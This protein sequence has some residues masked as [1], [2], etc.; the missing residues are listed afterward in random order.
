MLSN[1]LGV[2]NLC[3]ASVIVIGT[4]IFG[5]NVLE[6]LDSIQ[7]DISGIEDNV[8]L[9]LKKDFKTMKPE[10]Y[11]EL[12]VKSDRIFS[13]VSFLAEKHYDGD[14][15]HPDL[16]QY[17][18]NAY[19]SVMENMY[20][21]MFY[22]KVYESGVKIDMV[23]PFQITDTGEYLYGNDAI[24]EDGILIRQKYHLNIH[25]NSIYSRLKDIPAGLMLMNNDLLG[26]PECSAEQRP[27]VMFGELY[28]KDGQPYGVDLVT[29]SQ[30]WRVSFK[31]IDSLS[32]EG[33]RNRLIF[34]VGCQNIQK[35]IDAA[36]AEMP[37]ESD[38]SE[39]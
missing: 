39:E 18:N 22:K 2:A 23:K 15:F 6:T 25:G 12:L 3:L 37:K 10:T 27:F 31:D 16:I 19:D 13:H 26:Y 33:L 11:Q 34:K 17:A 30:G 29:E 7:G 24:N 32:P 38:I 36:D 8:L 21:N 9:K 1:Y 20:E 35:E 5:A 28:Q 14:I 4:G